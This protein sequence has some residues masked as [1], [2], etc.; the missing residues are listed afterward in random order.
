MQKLS[1]IFKTLHSPKLAYHHHHYRHHIAKNILIV[2][3]N[4]RSLKVSKSISDDLLNMSSKVEKYKNSALRIYMTTFALRAL[5]HLVIQCIEIDIQQDFVSSTEPEKRNTTASRVEEI[6]KIMYLIGQIYRGTKTSGIFYYSLF[7]ASSLTFFAMQSVS[8]GR[9]SEFYE[10]NSFIEFIRDPDEHNKRISQRIKDCVER[11]INSNLNFT[12]AIILQH[13]EL[14]S[15]RKDKFTFEHSAYT[16]GFLSNLCVSHNHSARIDRILPQRNRSQV[17]SFRSQPS[18][19]PGDIAAKDRVIFGMAKQLEYLNDFSRVEREVWPGN[20]NK[21]WERHLKRLWLKMYLILT[22][23]I[24]L[25]GEACVL[26]SL[27]LAFQAF[28]DGTVSEKFNTIS[29][30]DRLC[31]A[32]YCFYAFFGAESFLAPFLI[33]VIG[34]LDQTKCLTSLTPK[35]S[36]LSKKKKQLEQ[37]DYLGDLSKELEKAKREL[38]FECDRRALN[39]Y[40]CYQ[41]FQDDIRSIIILAQKIIGLYVTFTVLSLVPTFIYYRSIPVHHLPIFLTL[42][43][44]LITSINMTF[45][46]CAVL[47][48]SCRRTI[49]MAWSLIGIVEGYN[50]EC[51]SAYIDQMPRSKFTRLSDLRSSVFYGDETFCPVPVRDFEYSSRSCVTPHSILLWRRL[52]SKEDIVKEKFTCRLYNRINIDFTGILRTN[53]WVVSSILFV[54][55]SHN[56]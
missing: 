15:G 39:L 46:W 38:M 52:V 28:K 24:W 32:D 17:L 51:Y 45:C 2:I 40:I 16:G 34:I 26:V 37:L 33:L 19:L 4:L 10:N 5:C 55:T 29:F 42:S 22:P 1:A 49:K 20:R 9:I 36:D 13:R 50:R 44:S 21:S 31:S 25:S 47:N 35:F 27:Y 11:I 56:N 3:I 7:V 43:I 8:G 23:L 12:K 41:L 53:Y 54:L 30:I 18:A 14:S 48:A 6:H